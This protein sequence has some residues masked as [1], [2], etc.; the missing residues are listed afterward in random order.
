M[1]SRTVVQTV[2]WMVLLVVLFGLSASQVYAQ[3]R[4]TC[5]TWEHHQEMLSTDPQYRAEF[6][7]LD[8]AITRYAELRGKRGLTLRSGIVIIPVV[9]HVVYH[10]ATQNISQ[11]QI[12]SQI[13]VLNEDYRRLNADASSVPSAFSGVAAD[14]RIEFRL[15]LRDPNCGSTNGIT[16]TETTVTS[17]PRSGDPVKFASSGGHDAWPSDKYLNV[18]VCNLGESLAGYA[19]FPGDPPDRDGVVIL[20]TAFGRTGT[21][22]APLDLGRVA[23][24]EIG[25]WLDLYHIWGDDGSA[26]TGSDQVADTPNQ[27]GPNHGCPTFP[28]VSCSNG[29]NG[30]MF[31]NYMDYTVNACMYMFTAGQ[32]ARMDG[33]LYTAR[34]GIVA[35]DALVPPTAATDLWS[36]DS[37][38]D[39]GTEPNTVTMYPWTSDDIWVR[40]QNDG[41]TNQEHENPLYRS[42]GGAPNYVY[43]RVRNRACSSAGSATVKLYWAKAS[44]ALGWKDPWD[45][46][47]TSPV[48]MGHPIGT[49]STGS[50]PGG[51]SVIRTFPWFPP[52]PADYASFGADKSHFCL[53]SRIQTSAIAPYGMTYPET[54]DLCANVLNNNNIVW[55]NVQVVED[56]GARQ[57]W[58]TVGNFQ[59]RPAVIRLSFDTLGGKGRKSVLEWGRVTVNLGRSLFANWTAGGRKGAGVKVAEGTV[60]EVLSPKAWI[61]N[62]RFAPRELRTISVRFTSVKRAP[63]YDVYWF[64]I[65][66]YVSEGRRLRRIGGQSFVLKTKG[67]VG[68]APAVLPAAIYQRW[69]HSHEEDT[70]GMEVYRPASHEF[71]PALGRQGFEIKPDGEF[72]AYLIAPGDGTREVQ[73]R[74]T[75]SDSEVLTVQLE[76]ERAAPYSLRVIS[77]GADKLVIARQ[78]P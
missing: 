16:R 72:V 48:L 9:V 61:G 59:R 10:T 28:H 13:D 5:G 22:A 29:P 15:A 78:Q 2:A 76:G 40:R 20:Y 69:R 75:A 23:T 49:Q 41:V 60:I 6:T 37:A 57:A 71:P 52:N 1:R 26:C 63:G 27:A 45:G 50:V 73:G 46:S 24:H 19:T 44:T 31:M 42:P 7:R 67:S 38:G 64:D 55:K 4:W 3:E 68:E 54:S 53:L 30:D 43:V 47:V 17:F 8:R 51:G 62:L 77:V 39:D 58:V 32:S 12:Q 14:A 36:A 11:A 56:K 33:T 65:T 18:W 21:A 70:E 34:T 25:H 66:Q 74:W 35:S